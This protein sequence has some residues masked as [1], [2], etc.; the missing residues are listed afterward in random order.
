MGS[1]CESRDDE[2]KIKA[3]L[4]N[5][6]EYSKRELANYYDEIDRNEPY[7][8]YKRMLYGRYNKKHYLREIHARLNNLGTIKLLVDNMEFHK[9]DK[10]EKHFSVNE[11]Y[12]YKT[13]VEYTDKL[14]T[15]TDDKKVLILLNEIL[16]AMLK[17]YKY[18]NTRDRKTF[19]NRFKRMIYYTGLACTQEV[20]TYNKILTSP[21]IE[22]FIV[23]DINTEAIKTRYIEDMGDNILNYF[24]LVGKIVGKI[25][26]RSYTTYTLEYVVD[27]KTDK[28]IKNIILISE[29]WGWQQKWN[30]L[31]G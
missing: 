16:I 9:V 22:E 21:H 6:I 26:S 1:I 11:V 15:E 8:K 20:I 13:K 25:G 28:E 30:R 18:N 14:L 5:Y 2:K 12:C 3:N 19:M 17:P 23:G 27:N 31:T 24:D 10:I 29:G 7:R 4:L